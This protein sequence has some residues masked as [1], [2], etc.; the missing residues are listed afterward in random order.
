S[1]FAGMFI[2]MGC[3]FSFFAIDA[4]MDLMR[5]AGQTG[6]PPSELE[7]LTAAGPT[8][9]AII[10]VGI[11]LLLGIAGYYQ[12][13]FANAAFGGIQV[14]SQYVRSYLKAWPL[15]WIYVS[16]LVLIVCTLGLF[17]PWAKVRQVRYQ[18]AHTGIDSDGDLT[19]FTAASSEGIDAVGE[20]IGDFFDVDFGL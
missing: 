20:E 7:S 19:A 14:G 4:V 17:Y 15:I 9:W 13:S 16:N 6:L 18:L 12:A 5:T 3:I 1:F 10:L 8:G 2:Y 11:V